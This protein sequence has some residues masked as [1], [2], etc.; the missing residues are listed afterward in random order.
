MTKEYIELYF[1]KRALWLRL[2]YPL[3]WEQEWYVD[4]AR[5]CWVRMLVDK[6]PGSNRATG[7]R[8]G[9]GG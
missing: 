1:E 7:G 4:G 5:K 8:G 2:G 6:K 3:T 9:G